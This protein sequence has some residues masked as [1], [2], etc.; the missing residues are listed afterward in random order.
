[1][2]CPH[3][4]SYNCSCRKPSAGLILEYRRLFPDHHKTEL[5]IGDQLSDQ[6]CAESLQ[7]PFIRVQD[8]LSLYNKINGILAV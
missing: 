2:I 8:P 3:L 7:I 1:M 6:E 4:S 5:F